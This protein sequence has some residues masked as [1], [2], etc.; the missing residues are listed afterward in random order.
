MK[1][2]R[3]ALVLAS[4]ILLAPSVLAQ[5]SGNPGQNLAVCDAANDQSVP[6]MAATGD[7]KTWMGWFDERSG[8]YAVYVQLLDAGGVEQFPHNGLLVSANPQA[9]SLVDWDLK[10]DS[11]GNCVL[12]F[13]DTRAGTDLDVYAYRIT[14][15][16]TFLWGA[17]GVTLSNN[18]DYEPSPK[19]TQTSDGSFIV[20]WPRIPNSGTGSIRM[21][22]LDGNGV[23]Q[24]VADGI[25][26]QGGTNEKPAFCD[27]VA[28]D[29]GSYI[30]S[31]VRDISTFSSPRN[32][33][34]QKFDASGSALWASAVNV[35]DLNSLPI[36]YQPILQ[37]DDNGG[38]ILAWHR[39]LNNV[40]DALVQRLSSNGT[41]QWAH[42]GVLVSTEPNRYRLSPSVAFLP[43]SG[44]LIV[45]FQK[46]DL[47]ETQWGVGVQR[48]SS[49]GARLWTDNG[50]EIQPV[51]GTDKDFVR[52]VP[53]GNGAEVFCFDEPSTPLPQYRVIG[54]RLD[55]NGNEVWPT[56]PV[57]LSSVLASKD[58]LEAVIDGSGIA[59]CLWH[60]E[61]T[62]AGDMYAQ[63]VNADGSL[64]L[65]GCSTSTLCVGAANSV[66]PGASIG[67]TG[68]T[69]LA[70]NDFTL[71][72][73]GCPAHKTALFVYGATSVQVPLGNGYR[74]VG[75]TFARLRP[76]G[77][78]DAGGNFT[79]ATDNT[80]PPMGSGAAQVHAG[81]TWYFQL[82]YRDNVGAGFNLSN[83]L[84]ATFCP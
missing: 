82:Y 65:G 31:W 81:A 80:L 17:N 76:A 77:S 35:Y 60:D 36:A 69:S 29:A 55:G 64:G 71:T 39:S 1:T 32:L 67:T 20:V 70:L 79:R 54:F 34:A 24:F 19:L 42:N 41:E 11:Q 9:S 61:R 26:I 49:A 27:V 21:Q 52:C 56:V 2:P 66:G 30:V 40:Y 10:A 6:K 4:T 25:P 73:T 37:P 5:W 12:A 72:A 15:N 33:R 84:Q 22:K 46:T 18:A 43:A 38:A 48:I 28:G 75:G 14:Q 78:T 53:F 47:N 23:V 3:A 83:S 13:T 51:N 59:R 58:D 16:G 57:V 74:C 50:V 8:S 63:N 45:G 44:D 7:G 62:D 68:S